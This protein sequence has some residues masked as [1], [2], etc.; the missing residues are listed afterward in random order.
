MSK[1][2][3]EGKA[4]EQIAASSILILG[5][6]PELIKE[7]D[8]LARSSIDHTSPEVTGS[9]FYRAMEDITEL[10][11]HASGL[12]KDAIILLAKVAAVSPSLHII[13]LSHNNLNKSSVDVAEALAKSCT[14]HTIN[15]SNNGLLADSPEVTKELLKLPTLKTLTIKNNNIELDDYG[16]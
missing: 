12:S 5:N 1:R 4:E 11:A 10:D 6:K 3:R 7:L 16:L 2:K 9:R 8:K 15:L 14:L 13:N